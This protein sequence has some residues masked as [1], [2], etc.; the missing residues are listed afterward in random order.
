[1]VAQRNTKRYR[2]GTVN[3]LEAEFRP[4]TEGDCHEA[5]TKT[6]V[7]KWSWMYKN[8][9]NLDGPEMKKFDFFHVYWFYMND[10]ILWK[11]LNA[12]ILT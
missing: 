3:D 10:E 5:W 6:G 2:N 1:M 8:K 4:D 9:R 7:P 11:V 12:L